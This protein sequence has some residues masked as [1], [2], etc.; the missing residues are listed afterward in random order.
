MKEIVFEKYQVRKTKKQKSKFIEFVKEQSEKF[1]YQCQIEKGSFGARNIV[2]GDVDKA[3]VIYTAHYDTCARLP[4]PNFITPKN[5]GL[6][7]LFN[8]L[9]ALGIIFVMGLIGFIFG[10]VSGFTSVMLE[11]AFGINSD[12]LI[13]I[14]LFVMKFL[15]VILLALMFIGPAN[16]NTAND[17]TSG[18]MTLLTL[19]REMPEEQREKCAFIFFDLEEMGLFGSGSFAS[20]HKEIRKNVLLVNFDCVSDGDNFII[21]LPKTVHDNAELFEKAYQSEHFNVEVLKKGYIY[22][23]DQAKFKKGVAIASL[24][25]SKR[26]GFLYMDRIHTKKDTIYQQENIDFLVNA[27]VKLTEMM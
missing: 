26:F 5:I 23:S 15:Y 3:K 19:M 9:M 1:G 8:V 22:P 18:V 13:D 21:T 4:F 7:I 2:V 16:K 10:V 6:Y 24:K 17:N 11:T 27:S 20:K 12:V 25:K 14:S